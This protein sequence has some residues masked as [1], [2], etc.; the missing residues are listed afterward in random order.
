VLDDDSRRALL[1][2]VAEAIDTA[3][4]TLTVPYLTHLSMARAV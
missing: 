4:G 2:A 1:A 3:G